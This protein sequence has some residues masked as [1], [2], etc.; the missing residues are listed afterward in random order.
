MLSIIDS[1][2]EYAIISNKDIEVLRH[3][4]KNARIHLKNLSK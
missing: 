1:E 4:V 2:L 3:Y